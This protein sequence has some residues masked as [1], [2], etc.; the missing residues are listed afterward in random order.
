[1]LRP[2]RQDDPAD[3]HAQARPRILNWVATTRGEILVMLGIMMRAGVKPQDDFA[4]YWSQSVG[5]EVIK[6]AMTQKRHA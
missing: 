6:A 5:D 3:V 1:M 4:T 2:L